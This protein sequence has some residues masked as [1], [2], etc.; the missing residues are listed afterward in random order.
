MVYAQNLEELQIK[1]RGMFDRLRE[2]K[3]L[4]NAVKCE[5][6]RKEVNYL[7]HVI[8]DE[9]LALDPKKTKAVD[10]YPKP[11]NAKDIKSFLGLVGY[12]LSLIHIYVL[13]LKLVL[14]V[15]LFPPLN[16]KSLTMIG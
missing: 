3:L 2:H 6:L 4:L 15:G 16:P 9:G 13:S 5:F 12:Y 11:K 14:V 8:T 1:L 10:K 7:G